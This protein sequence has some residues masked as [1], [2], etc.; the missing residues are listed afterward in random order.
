[1]LYE[2]GAGNGT[3]MK[4]ILDYF[5][6]TRPD[7]YEKTE[8]NIIEISTKLANIQKETSKI[9]ESIE[10]HKKRARIINKSIFDWDVV[11]ERDCFVLAMEVIVRYTL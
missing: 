8:Y 11:E 2:I 1:M 6:E 3:L 9:H 10:I 7:V 4:N 5:L